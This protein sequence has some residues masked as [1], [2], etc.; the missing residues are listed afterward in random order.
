MAS[1]QAWLD[2][3][4]RMHGGSS[5]AVKVKSAY[6]SSP[7]DNTETGTGIVLPANALVED[8]WVRV[9]TAD[10]TETL[11]IGVS[12]GNLDDADGYLDGISLATNA[13]SALRIGSLASGA[14]TRGALLKE[15]GANSEV[16]A[17]PDILNG[18]GE[19]TYTTSSGT[20]TAQFIV[21]VKYLEL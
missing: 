4:A 17:K 5:K 7:T 8:V 2:K 14:V 13:S 12:G 15:T 11:D 20:D 10:A 19:I 9:V 6:I 21:Y 1:S 3:V 16:V 18:G